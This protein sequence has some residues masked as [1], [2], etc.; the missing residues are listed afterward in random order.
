MSV[1]E[2]NHITK[3]Y[4]NHKGLFDVN[5]SVEKGEIVGFLEP[6]GAGKTTLIRH[7]MG[8]IKPDSGTV[9]ILGKDC[10]HSASEIQKKTGYLPGEIAFLDDMT[11]DAFL[12]FVAEMKQM[13]D[14]SYMKELCDFLELNPKGR[15]RRMSKGMKQKIGIIIA[16]MD[17]PEILLLDEPTSGLDPLMQ[18]KFVE[19]IQKEKQN[20]TTILMSS[21]MFEEVENTCNRVVMIR[22]GQLIADE[23]M[24]TLLR[25]RNRICTITFDSKDDLLSFV[26]A[27][28]D[29]DQTG[30][31]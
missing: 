2:I 15:L 19:L 30:I 31:L 20:G 18:N 7:L 21:H 26:R 10:F 17:H 12:K 16:F 3:N 13:K 8:F 1:I 29:S 5:F 23:N 4:G 24:D 11:G 22:E 14:L 6:N 25:K 28:P 9:S 27:Y